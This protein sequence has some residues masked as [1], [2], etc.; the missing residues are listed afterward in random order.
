M[1]ERMNRHAGRPLGR[2]VSL[3]HHPAMA[4]TIRDARVADAAAIAAIYKYYVENTVV[5]FEETAPDAAEMQSRM[6]GV[7]A[8]GFPWL[9]AEE[10]GAV[11]AYAYARPFHT[12]SAY[13]FTVENAIYV[14]DGHARKGIGAALTREVIGRCAKAGCRQMIAMIAG[15]KDGP[16]VKMHAALGFKPVGFLPGLGWKFGQWID[17][18]QMQ[19]PLGEG[20]TTTPD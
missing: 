6:T 11:V 8:A 1:T 12:R 4:F 17:V 14:A 10:G 16:S 19:L 13:R 3:R 9:V 7:T 18:I 2:I 5:S 15:D 20:N